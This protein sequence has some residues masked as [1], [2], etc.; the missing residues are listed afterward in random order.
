MIIREFKK[1]DAEQVNNVIYNSVNTDQSLTEKAVLKIKKDAEP[2]FLIANSKKIDYFVCEEDNKIVGV[3]ALDNDELKTLY[4]LPEYRN[5]GIG[6]K[7]IEAREKRARLKG[8][9]KLFLYTHPSSEKFH[10]DNG[11]KIVKKFNDKAMDV[12]YMEKELT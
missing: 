6:S 1:E 11:F 4:V 3:G 7:L 5:R 2:S 9:K 8:I 12:V 10:L